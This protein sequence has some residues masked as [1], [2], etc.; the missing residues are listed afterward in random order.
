MSRPRG[1]MRASD[2]EAPTVSADVHKDTRPVTNTNQDDA[3]D[4]RTLVVPA[5]N[6]EGTQPVGLMNIPFELREQIF[7][8][9]VGTTVL[10]PPY[11]RRARTCGP[12]P[13]LDVPTVSKQFHMEMLAHVYRQHTFRMHLSRAPARHALRMWCACGAGSCGCAKPYAERRMSLKHLP[14]EEL[15]PPTNLW[16]SLKAFRDVRI[17]VDISCGRDGLSVQDAAETLDRALKVRYSNGIDSD[18]DIVDRR[19]TIIHPPQPRDST[20]AILDVMMDWMTRG[21]DISWTVDPPHIY[22]SASKAIQ[23]AERLLELPSKRAVDV[24]VLQGWV[25]F[26]RRFHSLYE[27]SMEIPRSVLLAH[28]RPMILIQSRDASKSRRSRT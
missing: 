27:E 20:S 17:V 24:T 16:T 10:R 26:M 28:A 6:H 22:N 11:D 14:Y 4:A 9:F 2:H 19:K 1:M 12:L 7:K 5:H 3:K 18:S 8:H 23:H 15:Y 25:E 21:H 13:H